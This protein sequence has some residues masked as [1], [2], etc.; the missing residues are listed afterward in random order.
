VWAIVK[1]DNA[2]KEFQV[3]LLFIATGTSVRV[4][5][6]LIFIVGV[7]ADQFAGN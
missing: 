4:L 3:I 2:L 5:I 1:I 6:P 7:G